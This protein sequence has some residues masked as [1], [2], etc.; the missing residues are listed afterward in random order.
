M[1]TTK[2]FSRER[3]NAEQ[4]INGFASVLSYD[5]ATAEEQW[6]WFSRQLSDNERDEIEQGGFDAGVTEGE[7]FN[8]MFNK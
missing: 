6:A 3:V 2:P 1:K 8:E 7:K 4:F 5:I